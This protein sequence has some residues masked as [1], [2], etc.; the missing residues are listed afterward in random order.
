MRRILRLIVL[1]LVEWVIPE[2]FD[3]MAAGHA[4]LTHGCVRF[5]QDGNILVFEP[6]DSVWVPRFEELN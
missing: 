4:A 2:A 6:V 5:D 3:A 1:K